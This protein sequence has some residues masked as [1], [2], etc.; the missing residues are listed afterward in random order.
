[1]LHCCEGLEGDGITEVEGF[2]CSSDRRGVGVEYVGDC[3]WDGD[4][5]TVEVGLCG[6]WVG[7]CAVEGF[8]FNKADAG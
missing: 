7:G 5:G 4:G 2:D 6:C 8:F 1:M 3:A